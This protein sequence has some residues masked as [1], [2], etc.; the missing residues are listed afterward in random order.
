MSRFTQPT[1]SLP[2]I[3]MATMAA[4]LGMAAVVI[5][6]SLIPTYL[7]QRTVTPDFKQRNV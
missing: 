3:G 2:I 5:V 7:D 1:I 6:L 4:I